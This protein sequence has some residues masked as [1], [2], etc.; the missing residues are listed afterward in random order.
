M[1]EHNQRLDGRGLREEELA[2]DAVIIRVGGAIINDGVVVIAVVVGVG[3]IRCSRALIGTRANTM[4]Y[5]YS[6]YQNEI[7][8]SHVDDPV[9]NKT[10]ISEIR[11]EP[12]VVARHDA[13]GPQ[14]AETANVSAPAMKEIT[15]A[16]VKLKATPWNST[17]WDIVVH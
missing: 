4:T 3:I 8:L 9:V 15:N 6:A 12:L 11:G 13:K 5:A 2:E 1:Q 7:P 14:A 17:K 10:A 16:K